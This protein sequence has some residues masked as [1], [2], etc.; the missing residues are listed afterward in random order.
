L[1]YAQAAVVSAAL[2]FM[3]AGA[4]PDV[5]HK[6]SNLTSHA[7]HLTSVQAYN[8]GRCTF[9]FDGKT[10][11][12]DLSQLLR[13]VLHPLLYGEIAFINGQRCRQRLSGVFDWFRTIKASEV[14]GVFD[15]T[16][17]LG[18]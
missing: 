8:S 15:N 16:S 18:S 6:A 5:V 7:R 4:Y 2:A 9:I 12:F 3:F 10:C 13:L 14:N 11:T 1:T 17:G